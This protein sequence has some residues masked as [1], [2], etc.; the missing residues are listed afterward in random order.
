MSRPLSEK[1]TPTETPQEIF[2]IPGNHNEIISGL[3][4]QKPSRTLYG[5]HPD[6]TVYEVSGWNIYVTSG[7]DGQETKLFVDISH[8]GQHSEAALYQERHYKGRTFIKLHQEYDQFAK[9]FFSGKL[10]IVFKVPEKIPE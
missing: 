10:S 2:K 9:D 4:V 3:L 7:H 1:N 5:I 8:P 6:I